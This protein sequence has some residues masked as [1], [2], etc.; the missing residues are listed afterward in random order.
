MCQIKRRSFLGSSA[1]R[2]VRILNPLNFGPV[3]YRMAGLIKQHVACSQ[4]V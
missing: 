3:L 1:R 4:R 2:M